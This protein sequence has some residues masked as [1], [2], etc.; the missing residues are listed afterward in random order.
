MKHAIIILLCLL[1]GGLPAAAERGIIGAQSYD[2][3]LGCTPESVFNLVAGT[4]LNTFASASGAT[5]SQTFEILPNYNN[6][7]GA[8]FQMMLNGA[9]NIVMATSGLRPSSFFGSLQFSTANVPDTTGGFA[10]IANTGESTVFVHNSKTDGICAAARCLHNYIWSTSGVGPGIDTDFVGPSTVVETFSEGVYDGKYYFLHRRAVPGTIGV[11]W[12]YDSS[13][14]NLLATQNLG[15][16]NNRSDMVQTDTHIYMVNQTGN[17]VVQISKNGLSIVTDFAITPA[18]VSGNIAYNATQNVFYIITVD[19]GLTVHVRRY[20]SDFSSNTH[21]NSIGIENVVAKAL[22]LDNRA[23]KLYLVTEVPAT[24]IVRI[25]RLNASTLATE[26]TLSIDRGTNNFVP[27][28]DF[29]YKNLWISDVGNPSH[30]QRIGLC[31]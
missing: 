7:Q 3:P 15:T 24:T 5:T 12:E 31:S 14:T 29:D 20:T 8:A 19:G 23:Q 16:F 13:G 25:R 18:T 26:Q 11:A 21:T 10:S 2:S 1:L 9:T 28:P 27:A 22:L 30:I 4:I 6:G 17:K